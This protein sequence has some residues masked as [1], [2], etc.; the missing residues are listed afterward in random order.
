MRLIEINASTFE[1]LICISCCFVDL[2]IKSHSHHAFHLECYSL[3]MHGVNE[4][5]L[6]D[7]QSTLDK[8]D[9]EQWPVH[10]ATFMK[11]L[12]VK[13]VVD[14]LSTAS[15]LNFLGCYYSKIK[16]TGEKTVFLNKTKSCCEET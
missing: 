13:E 10:I 12:N 5:Q 2:S 11:F 9:Y 6:R 8:N 16:R 4:T 3:E 1:L 15:T 7:L 14:V